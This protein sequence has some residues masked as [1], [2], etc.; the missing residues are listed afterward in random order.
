MTV[1]CHK[2]EISFAVNGKDQGVA[3]NNINIGPVYYFVYCG[4]C[5]GDSIKIN[6]FINGDT[7]Q[8]ENELN[9]SMQNMKQQIDE[10]TN[11]LQLSSTEI[12]ALTKKLSTAMAEINAL[13]KQNNELLDDKKEMELTMVELQQQ[14]DEL[15][16]NNLDRSKWREWNTQKVFYFIMSTVDYG[17]LKQYEKEIKQEIFESE[18]SGND[19]AD[20]KLEHLKAMGIKKIAVRNKVYSAIQELIKQKPNEGGVPTA[21]H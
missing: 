15:N 18:Y 16:R 9:D 13:K 1:D 21:Y 4:Y 5:K 7:E 20:V 3:Y 19:L 11:K 14:N 12:V 17:S 10:L 8:K 6:S 2:K